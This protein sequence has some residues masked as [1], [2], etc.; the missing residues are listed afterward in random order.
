MKK[1]R[2]FTIVELLVVIVVI[3]ILAAITIGAYNGVQ[4]RTNNTS[5]IASAKNALTIVNGYIAANGQYPTNV[6]FCITEDPTCVY[7]GVAWSTNTAALTE[8]KKIGSLPSGVPSFS[9][10]NRGISF[11]YLSTRTFNGDTMPAQLFYFLKGVGTDCGL[12]GVAN[13]GGYTTVPATVKYTSTVA[14]ENITIC[15]ITIIG[16]SA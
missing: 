3:A 16:P 4:Q 14:A 1:T 11:D 15:A 13:G 6:S 12:P 7:G 2:G 10:N 5:V 9:A 8:L